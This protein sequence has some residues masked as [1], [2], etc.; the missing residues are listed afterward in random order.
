MHEGKAVVVEINVGI[1]LQKKITGSTCF[2]SGV[3]NYHLTP[4]PLHHIVVV[5]MVITH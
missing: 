2:S 4:I 1:V 3:I 5:A